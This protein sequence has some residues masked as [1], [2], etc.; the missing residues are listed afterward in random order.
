MPEPE[1]RKPRRPLKNLPPDR[2]QP[3]VL[4]IWVVIVGAAAAL[5]YLTPPSTTSPATVMMQD[6][7]DYTNAHEV[8]SGFMRP[9]PS[10]VKD[11]YVIQGKLTTPKL[12]NDRNIKT[13]EFRAAGR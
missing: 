1:N 4:L 10:G 2:F 11:W 5:L 6:V 13:D 12:S 9:D 3:R 8:V 7:I